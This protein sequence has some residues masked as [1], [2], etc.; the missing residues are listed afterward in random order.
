MSKT[1]DTVEGGKKFSH[2]IPDSVSNIFGDGFG[3]AMIGYPNTKFTVFQQAINA[4]GTDT[5]ESEIVATVTVPTIALLEL[6]AHIQRVLRENKEQLSL[7]IN[8]Q[9]HKLL[10]E[11]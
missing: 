10:G 6:S 4:P 5:I 1:F 7:D 8:A 11:A 9:L 2:H 3:P